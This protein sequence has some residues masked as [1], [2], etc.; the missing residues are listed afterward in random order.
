MAFHK[1][2]STKRRRFIEELQILDYIETDQLNQPRVTI[3]TKNT[4]CGSTSSNYDT[5]TE[6]NTT[7]PRTK[8]VI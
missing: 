4:P 1:S 3:S 7:P 8:L 2:K 6:L 5:H